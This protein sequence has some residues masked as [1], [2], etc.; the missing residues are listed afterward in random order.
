MLRM[1]AS[2]DCRLANENRIKNSA[3]H[4]TVGEQHRDDSKRISGQSLCT[5]T[6]NR[7]HN[8]QVISK[9]AQETISERKTDHITTTGKTSRNRHEKL[10]L[11]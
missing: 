6:D 8:N 3:I 7:I 4:V 5:G 1:S 11:N 9:K 10:N 2:R